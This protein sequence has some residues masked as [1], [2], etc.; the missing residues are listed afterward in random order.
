MIRVT[1][2]TLVLL[3]MFF[4]IGL[5]A[6]CTVFYTVRARLIQRKKTQDRIYR[7]TVCSHVYVDA[8]FTG[9]VRCPRC[10]CLNE[11]VRN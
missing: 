5:V 10:G 7:C 4:S 3:P 11:P 2:T 6:L 9:L 1:W 8:R